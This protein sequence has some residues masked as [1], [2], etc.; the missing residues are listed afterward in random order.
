MN[1]IKIAVLEARVYASRLPGKV[2]M[3][4]SG[5]PML[6]HIVNR[7]KNSKKI[8]KI[9]I[10][11]TKNS[12]DDLIEILANK[13]NIEVF[14]GS[15][16]NVMSRVL[17]ATKKHKNSILIQVTGDNPFIES[18]VIDQ[19]IEVIENRNVDY[20]CNHLPRK[21]PLGCEV[22]VY[23][24]DSLVKLNKRNLSFYHKSNVTSIFYAKESDY[25]II[26]INTDRDLSGK[27]YRLTVDEVKDYIL[28]EHIY[29]KLY[30]GKYISLAEVLKYLS[31]NKNISQINSTVIQKK[32]IEG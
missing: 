25:K 11:T 20:V 13:M 7:I 12:E 26:N 3:P 22:R 23:N 24:R 16:N 30:K 1:K 9:V 18:K 10:A 4:L 5:I 17:G 31:K 28:V 6:E 2:M 19:A 27:K 8:D 21:V 29:S 15:K 32:I 14:R